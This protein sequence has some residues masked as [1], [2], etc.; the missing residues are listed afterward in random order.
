MLSRQK[1]LTLV[2]IVLNCYFREHDVF[3]C[4]RLSRKRIAVLT[5][6]KYIAIKDKR[7]RIIVKN[8]VPEITDSLRYWP[9]FDNN[10]RETLK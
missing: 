7:L 4:V 2:N 8:N 3:A 5:G 6:S 9:M 10:L 1:V